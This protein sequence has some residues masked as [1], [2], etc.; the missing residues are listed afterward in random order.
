MKVV[1]AGGGIGG[2]CAGI[3]LAKTGFEVEV[4]ERAPELT[5][6]GAGIQLSPNA[7]KGLA[8]LGVLE[9]IAQ[10]ASNLIAN[11]I[12]YN[13]PDGQIRVKVRAEGA[14]A[15][16]T[17]RD[18]GPGISP[19]D[20]GQIFQ[21]FFRVDQ[22][23]TRPAGGTGLGLAICKS[24]V[25]AHGGSIECESVVGKGSTFRVRLPMG[26]PPANKTSE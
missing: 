22:S 18:T 25:E 10:V 17:V 26:E 19:E 11:A 8:G 3:A 23:R 12:H 6:V 14:E 1:I 2:L 16:L 9:A 20:L 7:T 21:R 13:K 5:D 15:V 24:I 4:V